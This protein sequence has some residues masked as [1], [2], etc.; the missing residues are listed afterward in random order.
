MRNVRKIVTVRTSYDRTQ[1]KQIGNLQ[2]TPVLGGKSTKNEENPLYKISR[3]RI[4]SPDSITKKR[5]CVLEQLEQQDR[6]VSEAKGD[7]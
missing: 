7:Y 4:L 3:T 5:T 1:K 6:R 2:N